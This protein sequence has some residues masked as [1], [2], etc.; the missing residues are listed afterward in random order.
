[1]EV[2]LVDYQEHRKSD[3][4]QLHAEVFG[5]SLATSVYAEKI[6]SVGKNVLALDNDRVVGFG[7]SA[8]VGSAPTS[9][10]SSQLD[11]INS[12]IKWSESNDTR[13]A[14]AVILTHNWSREVTVTGFDC[15]HEDEP[16]R[17]LNSDW[18]MSYLAV[19]PNYRSNGLGQKLVEYRMNIARA[20]QASKVFA[21]L[22]TE[23]LGVVR[24][25]E[26]LQFIPI[27]ELSNAYPDGSPSRLVYKKL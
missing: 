10:Q 7:L 6:L 3:V 25:Y 12:L 23:S 8:T 18:Y 26:K 15:D 20:Y 21:L 1:M 13:S 5:N 19:A 17:A 16:V 9:S 24:I 22:H 11:S 27:I 14:L 2:C 4:I